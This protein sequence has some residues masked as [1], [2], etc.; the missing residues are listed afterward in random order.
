V[1]NKS[2]LKIYLCD[3]TYDTIIHVSDTIPINIGYVGSY[4]KKKFGDRVE[5]ELFKYPEDILN[6]LKTSPPDMIALSNYSW[7]SNLSEFIASVAKK[8]NPNIITVQGGTNFPYD[9]PSQ[10]EF[11]IKR[12]STD[13]YA[14]LEGEKTCTNVVQRMFDV[15]K[16]LDHFFDT[17]IDGCIF[18]KPETRNLKDVVAVRGKLLDRIKDL[19]EI[20]SP[21]LTGML[22]KFF[23]GKLTPFLETNRGCPFTCSFCHT[24]D[25]YFHKLNKFSEQRIKDE[26]EYIGKKAGP[27]GITNLHLADVNFG[28][29]PTDKKTCEFFL[30]SKEK[31]KWPLQIIGT[32]GKNSKE[33]VMEITGILG[34]MFSV[35]MAMQSLSETVLQNVGRANIKLDHMNAINERLIQA[36]RNTHG[37][38][39]IPLPGETKKSF[40]DGLN[41]ML[42]SNVSLVCV[43]TLMMLNGTKFQEPAYKKKY[44]Y[45]TRFRIVPL[46]FGEYEGSKILDYEEVGIQT[47]DLSFQDYLDSRA[48]SLLVE[49]L[50]NGRPFNEFFKYASLFNIQPATMLEIL[51]NNI[52]HATEDIKK[53]VNDF[54]NE[55][56]KELWES[57]EKLLDH[58]RK[59][60]N[61]Q[62]LKRG[63]VGGNLIYKYKSLNI[64]KCGL[65]WVDFFEEQL[66]KAIKNKQPELKSF[67]DLKNE[68]ADIANFSRLKIDG[69]FDV[70]ADTKPVKEEFKYNV[71]KWIDEGKKESL[72]NYKFE[73]DQN[74]F[75][76]FSEEQIGMRDD[77]FKRYGTSINSISKIV[78]RISGLEGQYRKIRLDKSNEL[79][80]IY[81][82]VG[83]AFATKY[84]MSG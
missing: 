69:L 44:E 54:I 2:K 21:Y 62:K 80:S 31:Y 59:E 55:T 11:L 9:E 24:G 57:E 77:Y 82:K 49:S 53:V 42:N 16:D 51:H 43:Y 68:I 70:N 45:K 37:E 63:E 81:R 75:F 32:T 8:N 17:A 60:E 76:E 52:S 74:I 20:P 4:I 83:E 7:N 79:R 29:Y 26:I 23:D 10:K 64:V 34:D 22:D 25:H 71:V 35:N 61:Y 18:I 56:E 1:I 72:K 73:L 6:K 12:P 15:N 3:I 46:N 58:Y 38:L 47:K 41:I 65:S 27:L 50:Y 36:G 5:I 28:M 48:I 40:I 13:V 66:F 14:I 30:E 33:R 19:D 67:A 78:T 39:I 84:A